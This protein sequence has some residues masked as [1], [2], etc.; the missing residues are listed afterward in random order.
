MST[1]QDSLT[2][3]IP[4]YVR[5]VCFY[6]IVTCKFINLELG[7]FIV[8]G[9]SRRIMIAGMSTY[10]IHFSFLASICTP[11]PPGHTPSTATHTQRPL[12]GT[13]RQWFAGCLWLL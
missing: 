9:C 2:S 10:G 13:W 4:R 1:Y 8:D 3:K 11:L 7:L 6:D 12:C 5:Q